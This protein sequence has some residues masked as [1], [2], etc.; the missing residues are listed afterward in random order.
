MLVNATY[1]I[2]LLLVTRNWRYHLIQLDVCES[3]IVDIL[4]GLGPILEACLKEQNSKFG[5]CEYT[6]RSN[7]PL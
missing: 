3:A 4:S 6:R 7:R 2:F 5:T 1:A